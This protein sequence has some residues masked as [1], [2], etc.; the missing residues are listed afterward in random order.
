MRDNIKAVDEDISSSTGEEESNPES[1]DGLVAAPV[2][3]WTNLR[4]W[5]VPNSKHYY[6]DGVF[7]KDNGN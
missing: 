1:F 3:R 5:S 6:L 4:R 7:L 2:Y